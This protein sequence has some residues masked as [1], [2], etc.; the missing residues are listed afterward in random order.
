M[1]L[2]R[3][4]VAGVRNLD[5]VDLSLTPG[6]NLFWGENGAGKTALLEAVHVLARGR[7]FRGSRVQP[8]IQH[9]KA[10][11]LVRARIHDESRGIVDLAL[12]KTRDD[13]S[14]LRIGGQ[15]ERRISA[16]AALMPLQL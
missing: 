4:E 16:A 13:G 15:V 11:L 3:L 6:L 8:L 10:G 9:E 7:S 5:G 14:D 12:V 2:Q 1:R